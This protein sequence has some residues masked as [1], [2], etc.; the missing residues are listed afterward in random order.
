MVAA[1]VFLLARLF[2]LMAASVP[3]VGNHEAALSGSLIATVWVGSI[4]AL[5]GA[6]IAIAQTDIKRI[7]AYSTVSQLGF[8]ML[9]LGA[10]GPAVAMFHL[11]T[12]AFFKALLFLGAGSVIHGCHDIQDIRRMGGLKQAMPITFATY[13]IGML[14]L[15]GFP[16]FFSGFWSKDAILHSAHAWSPSHLPFF[17]G[18]F[19]AFLTAFYMTRQMCYVFFG[20][21]RL[22][23][24]KTKKTKQLTPH[25]SP[26]IMTW[27]LIVLA[28]G[29]I[30]L[31]FFGTP[32]LPAFQGYLSGEGSSLSFGELFNG[33]SLMVMMISSVIAIGGIAAAWRFYRADAFDPA[34]QT[35]PVQRRLPRFFSFA[36]RRFNID[37]CYQATVIRGTGALATAADFLDRQVFHQIVVVCSLIVRAIAWASRLTDEH[38]VNGLFDRSCEGVGIGARV[39]S[40]IQSGQA[41]RYLK[42]VGSSLVFLTVVIVWISRS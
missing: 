31:G 23:D 25:E 40:Q 14:A 6:L 35:D 2:P 9:G 5:I 36:E 7:L 38:L 41:Q 17:I 29:A 24:S 3:E 16:L 4:T 34:N 10:G 28:S 22:N 39:V 1:G 19:A 42:I 21:N 37:E 32:A 26:T 30:L 33:G 8:M 18:L 11:I 27:P 20:K 15:S 12:H 13:G